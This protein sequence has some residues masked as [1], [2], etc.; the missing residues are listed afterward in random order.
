MKFLHNT[1]T[2]QGVRPKLHSF[3]RGPYKITQFISEM[4]YKFCGIEFNKE[5]T[6]HYDRIKPGRSPPGD[7]VPRTNTPPEPMQPE[8]E[9]FFISSTAKCH[10]CFCEAR[11]TCTPTFCPVPA[12]NWV[13]IVQSSLRT[14]FASPPVANDNL[15]ESS[16]PTEEVIF[17]N[18][19]ADF[20]LPL[21]FQVPESVNSP[22]CSFN[23]AVSATPDLDDQFPAKQTVIP[24]S[25]AGFP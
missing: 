24:P 14:T 2:P 7:F 6:V 20:T 13:L 23:T 1:S 19:S 8:N 15:P 12:S 16:A 9:I 22:I 18:R 21:F 17:P 11:I 4:T 5:L 10:F 25:R 3:W